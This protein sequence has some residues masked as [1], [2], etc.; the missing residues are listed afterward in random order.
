MNRDSG[1]HDGDY[2][3]VDERFYKK[4]RG[5]CVAA[6]ITGI[7]SSAA[8][9]TSPQYTSAG[10]RFGNGVGALIAFGAIAFLLGW[11]ATRLSRWLAKA[12]NPV[13]P[14]T[15]RLQWEVESRKV[16]AP[17]YVADTGRSYTLHLDQL[18]RIV[19]DAANPHW[20]HGNYVAAVESVARAV[21]AFLQKSV[22]SHQLSGTDLVNKAFSEHSPKPG[23]ARLR[24]P[25]DRALQTWTSRMSGAKAL[26][27]ACFSGIRNVVAHEHNPDWTREDAFEYLAMFS[28][29]VRWVKECE[30]ETIGSC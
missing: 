9:A 21:N 10:T 24:F 5:A 4:Y 11:L 8:I 22:G 6:A 16:S 20:P 12:K 23:E 7:V 27:T 15:D 17:G 29:F 13:Q 18:D 25:G 26:G 19:R 30:V 1:D 14:R 28:V 3:G 2:D